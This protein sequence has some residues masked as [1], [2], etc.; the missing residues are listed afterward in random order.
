[1]AAIEERPIGFG[2][3][4]RKEDARFIRGQGKYLDDIVLPG[5]LHGAVLRSPFAHAKIVS[6]DASRALEHPKVLRVITAKDLETLG[7][8]WMPTI[9]CLTTTSAFANAASVA[10]ASPVSQSKQWLSVLPSRSVRITAASGS[11]AFRASITG[12]NG[13]YSTSI[14]SSASRAE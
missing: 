4:K 11:S 12:S 7:L 1:M 10:A 14:N 8:A 3:M 9:S 13:S 5:M 6:I 2:R